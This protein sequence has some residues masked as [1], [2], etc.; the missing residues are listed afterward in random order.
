MSA[1]IRAPYGDLG[2]NGDYPFDANFGIRVY[3]K[4]P[5]NETISAIGTEAATL[6]GGL[7]VNFLGLVPLLNGEKKTIGTAEVLRIT[8]A[9]PENMPIEEIEL[10]GFGSIDDAV[11][12]AKREHTEEFERDGVLTVY[13]YRV[14]ELTTF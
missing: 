2:L 14:T 12:Y 5:Q 6:K 7:R 9:K 4:P 1:V 10:C 3:D 11:V 8:S 13:R